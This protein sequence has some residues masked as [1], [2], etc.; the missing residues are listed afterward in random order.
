MRSSPRWRLGLGLGALRSCGGSGGWPFS[1]LAMPLPRGSFP[2]SLSRRWSVNGAVGIS[3]MST[4]SAISAKVGARLILA[5]VSPRRA[6][7]M[8]EYGYDFEVVKPPLE[9]P[10]HVSD[11][12]AVPGSGG[13]L[14]LI[15]DNKRH[16]N[17]LLIDQALV[18]PA[19]LPQEIT[20]IGSVNY[21]CIICKSVFKYLIKNQAN[22]NIHS[23]NGVVIAGKLLPGD[24]K[25]GMYV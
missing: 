23:G 14:P 13:N 10:C 15:A 3:G 16:V 21:N 1:L 19:M 12:V 4:G 24:F 17:G 5:S 20:L 6:A 2:G 25:R 7:L 9:E 18:K 11:D 8:R 22:T